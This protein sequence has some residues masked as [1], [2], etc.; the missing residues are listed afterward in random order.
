MEY[1]TKNTQTST[2]TYVQINKLPST[3]F[4]RDNLPATAAAAGADHGGGEVHQRVERGVPLPVRDGP[5]RRRQRVGHACRRDVH[6]VVGRAAG[7]GGAERGPSDGLQQIHRQMPSTAGDHARVLEPAARRHFVRRGSERS[8]EVLRRAG[9]VG[10]DSADGVHTAATAAAALGSAHGADA[11]NGRGQVVNGGRQAHD[12]TDVGVFPGCGH[13]R[14]GQCVTEDLLVPLLRHV[15]LHAALLERELLVTVVE[16][17][18]VTVAVAAAVF[19]LSWTVT[20]H[21]GDGS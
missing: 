8:G 20:A 1:T 11:R 17:L 7:G 5:L 9:G 21:P 18:R 3:G 16:A 15:A 10:R 2:S 12:F 6:G 19:R 4:L 14:G 13:A